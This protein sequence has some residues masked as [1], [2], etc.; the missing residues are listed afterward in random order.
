MEH[1]VMRDMLYRRAS[2]APPRRTTQRL[3][4]GL[5]RAEGR[6]SVAAVAGIAR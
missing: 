5:T 6:A 4:M 1:D 2:D 3:G